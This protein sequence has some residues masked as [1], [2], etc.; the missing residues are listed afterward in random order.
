MG[1][2]DQM[3]IEQALADLN[4]SIDAKWAVQEGSLCKTFQFSG[5]DRAF[6]FMTAL[7]LYA[8]KVDHHPDWRN[9]YRRVDI[10]L[11][12]F[13]V[14][15]LSQKDFDFAQQAETLSLDHA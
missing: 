15:G 6:S 13:D 9:C 10:R 1:A 5:F 7:A 8:D 14:K 3:Q 4:A 12:T 11:T 2:F